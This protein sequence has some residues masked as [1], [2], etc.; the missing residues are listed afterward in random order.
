MRSLGSALTWQTAKEPLGVSQLR[1][2][3][4]ESI[5]AKLGISW[6]GRIDATLPG[7]TL[8]R[9]FVKPFRLWRSAARCLRSSMG[10]AKQ[11]FHRLCGVAVYVGALALSHSVSLPFAYGA[12]LGVS[13]LLP[14]SHGR[15]CRAATAAAV[16]TTTCAAAPLA[17]GVFAGRVAACT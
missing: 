15:Y 6:P 4:I 1:P 10:F 5:A 11:C 17:A 14:R 7:M 2:S 3:A 9:E 12:A 16:A 8:D 13:T